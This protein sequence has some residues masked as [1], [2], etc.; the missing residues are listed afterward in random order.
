MKINIRKRII[1]KSTLM[2]F[3]FFYA[4]LTFA[5]HSTPWNVPEAAKL[6]KNPYPSEEFSLDRGKKSYKLDC[7]RCH[8]AGG[9]GDGTS[10]GKLEK[11]VADLSSDLVQ[12]QSDGELYWKISEGRKP[13]PIAK[14][15]LTDDQRWDIINYIRTFKKT[16]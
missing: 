6:K 10:S 5:Q 15:T 3:A 7:I 9:K 8:G 1:V 4:T 14:R 12:N 2:V 16:Q 13:M 11:T